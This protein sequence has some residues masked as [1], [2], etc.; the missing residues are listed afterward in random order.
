MPFRPG[1][2]RVFDKAGRPLGI[3]TGFSV[4]GPR[5]YRLNAMEDFSFHLPRNDDTT[6]ILAT[7]QPVSHIGDPQSAASTTGLLSLPVP[8]TAANGDLLL[9]TVVTRLSAGADTATNAPAG[10]DLILS[11]T[12]GG[13]YRMDTFSRGVDG[14]EGAAAEF[15]GPIGTGGSTAPGMVGTLVGYR[16]ARRIFPADQLATPSGTSHVSPYVAARYVN[17]RRVLAFGGT[18]NVTWTP[19]AGY[20]EIIEQAGAGPA[21]SIEHTS[22]LV[23]AAGAQPIV[24]ATSSGAVQG[25]V[26]SLVIEQVAEVSML[27]TEDNLIYVQNNTPMDPWAGV[28]DDVNYTN[29]TVTVRAAGALALCEKLDADI[30]QDE[31]KAA[32]IAERLIDAAVAQQSAHGDLMLGFV[33]DD[34]GPDNPGLYTFSGEIVSGLTQLADDTLSEFYF[35]PRIKANGHLAIDLHWGSERRI[36]HRDIVIHDGPG[37]QIV[38]GISIDFNGA[39]RINYAKLTGRATNLGLYVNYPSIRSVIVDITPQTSLSVP[40]SEMVGAR[41]R[42]AGD[43]T[44]NWG[45]PVALEQQM[46]AAIEAA[47]IGYYKRFLYAFHSRFGQPFLDGYDWSG[48]DSNNE[49]RLIASMMRTKSFMGLIGERGIVHQLDANA[50]MDASIEDWRL[51]DTYPTGSTRGASRNW[52][53]PKHMLLLDNAG[54][55]Y[56]FHIGGSS[57]S[58]VLVSDRLFRAVEASET[59]RGVSTDPSAPEFVWVLTSSPAQAIVRKYDIDA[60]TL[61]SEWAVGDP[62]YDDL[63]V[64]AH[65]GLVWL[66]HSTTGAIVPFGITDGT[67]ANTSLG[68]AQPYSRFTSSQP[69]V[70]GIALAASGTIIYVIHRDGEVVIFYTKDGGRAGAK[71]TE[72]VGATG[73]YVSVPDARI[74]VMDN[75]RDIRVYRA[76]T[77]LATIDGPD[78]ADG[79]PGFQDL[80]TGQFVKVVMSDNRDINYPPPDPGGGGGGSHPYRPRFRSQFGRWVG[81]AGEIWNHDTG[82]TDHGAGSSWTAWTGAGGGVLD[83]SNCGP[84]ST[85]MALD[86]HTNG[87]L[88]PIPP[89]VRVATGDNFSGTLPQAN[90][91]AFDKLA[92]AAGF[93][94]CQRDWHCTWDEFVARVKSGKGAFL[95]GDATTPLWQPYTH[96]DAPGHFIYVN[97]FREGTG[98]EAGW[99]IFDPATNGGPVSPRW[100][101]GRALRAFGEAYSGGSYVW[102]FFTRDTGSGNSTNRADG[103]TVWPDATGVLQLIDEN[104]AV[105][106]P[107]VVT[108]PN[109]LVVYTKGAWH[110]TLTPGPSPL[111]AARIT[112]EWKLDGDQVVAF[113][114]RTEVTFPNPEL[115]VAGEE[116]RV[117]AWSPTEMGYGKFDWSYRRAGISRYMVS[118]DDSPDAPKSVEQIA[119]GLATPDYDRCAICT[120]IIV[121][122]GS[123]WSHADASID[124]DHTA[125]W[126]GTP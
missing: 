107:A 126:K 91:D 124:A 9:A 113:K 81:G 95:A 16:N 100:V 52:R 63:A 62:D 50:D 51:L 64:D 119:E 106:A 85:A 5:S 71:Q 77:A 30:E 118:Y 74:W 37:G 39:D 23:A 122:T 103:L 20:T 125:A 40:E 93:P 82:R 73:L 56:D 3:I 84:T 72:V 8:S 24:S 104:G 76:A 65:R 59:P 67:E 13:T 115:I 27:L 38:P 17:S 7:P 101:P 10:W 34:P 111:D 121:F 61:L 68:A 31:G 58:P 53:N 114:K 99:Y 123:S 54:V 46:A 15:G 45:Y 48:P 92:N 44:V 94:N 83:G 6:P 60:L 1:Q 43:F 25:M 36:D 26:H 22:R 19:P 108:D 88:Q 55:L 70:R 105:V 96:T 110:D 75:H 41:R 79:A 42:V 2:L 4:V 87:A 117:D 47:Y 66:G 35:L 33:R 18:G 78:P 21:V 86:R 57:T 32:D 116:G 11:T 14:S 49:R 12:I 98:A 69:T 120:E 28:I 97:E 90:A 109:L 29:G 112:K 80:V 89:T 102:A